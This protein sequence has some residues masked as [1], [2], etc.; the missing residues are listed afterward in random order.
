MMALDSES[1][2]PHLQPNLALIIALITSICGQIPALRGMYQY[3]VD[4]PLGSS[5]L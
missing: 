2:N 3:A 1:S 5:L 4:L